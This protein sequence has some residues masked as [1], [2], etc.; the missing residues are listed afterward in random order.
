MQHLGLRRKTSSFFTI[1]TPLSGFLHRAD[2]P[3]GLP[4]HARRVRTPRDVPAGLS[5]LG[6]ALVLMASFM[7]VLDFSIVNVALPSIRSSLSFGGDSVQWV[8][9]A[10]AIVFGALLILG[11]RTAD[12]FGRRRALVAGLTIFTLASLAGG[13]AHDALLLVLARAVQG[14]GAALVAPASLSLITAHIKEGP[15]RTRALA[16]YGATAS[17]GF[18]AGQV[19][20]G[21]LVQFATWRWVFLVNVP[22][23]AAG[24]LVAPYWLARDHLRG[25]LAH[26][27]F[28]GGVL[29]MTSVASL[30]YAVS[31]GPVLGWHSAS[32]IAAFIVTIVSIAGFIEVERTHAHPL[33]NLALFKRPSLRST[34]V[35]TVFLGM[36]T[37]GELVVMSI[38]LQQSLHESALF[39]GLVI[40]PQGLMGFVTGVVG[41]RLVRR[42]GL[43]RLLVAAALST[44]IG[45]F[46]LAHLPTSGAFSPVF[47]AVIFIGF[48]TVGTIFASTAIATSGVADADQGLVGAVVNTT[49]QVGAALG[50]ALM[51][52][53]A[54]GSHARSGVSTV[55]GD[56]SALYVASFIALLAT[57]VAWRAARSQRPAPAPHVVESTTGPTVDRDDDV[58]VV[59]YRDYDGPSSSR[60]SGTGLCVASAPGSRSELDGGGQ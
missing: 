48:G 50:V 28:G 20:G 55:S 46:I 13:L 41:V 27:D 15:R 58:V 32:I 38:Y 31:Q 49:R 6:L 45:F 9:T 29:S 24:A 21:L 3:H 33:V 23:G 36:W 17:V 57:L 56:R 16:L 53:V 30:V 35:I 34:S 26:V 22:F 18:V 11:G 42:L 19:L 52:A 37:A 59:A 2:V 39:A 43:H 54:D 7:V 14:I 25:R 10:Y 47:L 44:L 40:A 5:T 60:S 51:V 1:V 4:H 12:L 8:V